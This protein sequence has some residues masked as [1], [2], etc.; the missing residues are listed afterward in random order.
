M[1]RPIIKW[2]TINTNRFL[3]GLVDRYHNAVGVPAQQTGQHTF[4]VMQILDEVFAPHPN[5]HRIMRAALHH[6]MGELWA[7]D[8]PHP[9]K[10]ANPAIKEA[11]DAVEDEGISKLRISASLLTEEEKLILK[12]CDCL[13][14]TSDAADE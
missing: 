11:W 2:E 5:I 6:D 1:R 12:F 4:G 10:A 7:G 3:A 14:Y 8:A 9:T 13:L